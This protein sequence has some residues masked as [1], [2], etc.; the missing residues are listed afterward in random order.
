MKS[1]TY[2]LI[3]RRIAMRSLL[4]ACLMG[5]CM[6][7][8]I[9]QLPDKLPDLVVS[10]LT[11]EPAE[12]E[13]GD[14]V[15]FIAEITNIGEG[16]TPADK[17]HGVRFRVD[18]GT[19]G[20]N[21]DFRS[22]MKPGDKFYASPDPTSNDFGGYWYI[23]APGI[24]QIS[25][26]IDDYCILSQGP[27]GS[28]YCTDHID[29]K[30][31][32]RICESDEDNNFYYQDFDIEG[33]F[34]HEKRADLV[35]TC[36]TIDPEEPSPGDEV[37]FSAVVK[38]QGD[39]VATSWTGYFGVD[40]T[41]GETRVTRT[42]FDAM[43][44]SLEPGESKI[45]TANWS[46][47]EAGAQSGAWKAV[48]GDTILTAIVDKDDNVKEVIETNNRFSRM[49]YIGV[50][51]SI[52][53]ADLIVNGIYTDPPDPVPFQ[54]VFLST[55][56][57]NQG[58][59]H[60]TPVDEDHTIKTDFK[61]SGVTISRT[62]G[63]QYVKDSMPA[64]DTLRVYGNQV[65][66]DLELDGAWYSRNPGDYVITCSV[67]NWGQGDS[68]KI[69]ESVETNNFY[70][71][72]VTVMNK[73]LPEDLPDL[74]ISTLSWDPAEP[75]PGDSMSFSLTVKNSGSAAT[76]EGRLFKAKLTVFDTVLYARSFQSMQPGGSVILD[77]GRTRVPDQ[78]LSSLV[79]AA[80][81]TFPWFSI[82]E[83]TKSNNMMTKGI[84]SLE[85]GAV[86]YSDHHTI[87][88]YPIPA[89]DRLHI[90]YDSPATSMP[91]ISITTL[92]GQQVYTGWIHFHPGINHTM[93]HTG[94]LQAGVY[95]LRLD[96]S[97]TKIM[98]D[99][100]R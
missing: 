55:D 58:E 87:R 32:N 89:G 44:T 16:S 51:D 11:W 86:E 50:D 85:T 60:T 82:I 90:L 39:T 24:Y 17:I 53:K 5:I 63:D 56:L 37:V 34:I 15:M 77:M 31:E 93:I 20:W 6:Q 70:S 68:G 46:L 52:K 66:Y 13:V 73:T 65:D 43:I 18:N 14:S 75:N 26:E 8:T 88:V 67:D 81:D 41:V 27:D 30:C 35:I 100:I 74:E 33:F 7:H 40:F 57:I 49:L 47:A 21:A 84:S 54:A 96:R 19:F 3:S 48:Q 72:V 64:G 83:S 71:K 29:P 92:S 76:P 25:I 4:A 80:V 45:Q 12:P 95:L 69:A 23:T 38:N 78:V 10:D 62:I 94:Q 59:D 9:A 28:S 97:V 42:A 1:F 79:T 36:L 91:M 61:I 98:I 2:F 22:S 99:H